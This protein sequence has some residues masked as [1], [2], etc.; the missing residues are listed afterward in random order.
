MKHRLTRARVLAGLS[1]GQAAKLLTMARVDLE[2]LEAGEND[3]D[4]FTAR[5]MADVYG[6]GVPWMLGQIPQFA[7]QEEVKKSLVC[8]RTSK[9]RQ[10]T[11]KDREAIAEFTAMLKGRKGPNGD[12]G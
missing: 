9:G 11:D 1:V 2:T 4:E 3:P 5:R 7:T 10:I 8:A 12:H 6:V